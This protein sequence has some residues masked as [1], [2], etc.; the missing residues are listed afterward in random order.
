[1]ESSSL[2]TS[3]S[4][5]LLNVIES[6]LNISKRHHFFLWAQGEL[7]A[8]L[9]HESL[10]CCLH[11][12]NGVCTSVQQFSWKPYFAEN[13]LGQSVQSGSGRFARLLELWS[14]T[15]KPVLIDMAELE[16]RFSDDVLFAEPLETF[17]KAAVHGVRGHDGGAIS[18]FIFF[19][20]AKS[21]SKHHSLILEFVVPHMHDALVRAL[22]TGADQSA[23]L[24]ASVISAREREVLKLISDGKTN[25]E[26]AQILYLSPFTVKS[27]I[28][29]IFKKLNTTSRS[30]AVALALAR[31]LIG[32]A[33]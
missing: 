22:A 17:S 3:K 23:I 20:A 32:S 15:A 8:L 14:M 18:S 33:R 10:V 25:P 16:G 21:L 2:G 4:N 30:Q 28:K 5:E 11:G 7:Q 26:I 24:P 1:M 19:G 6:S 27:H 31:G 9:P 29:N 13:G 12:K